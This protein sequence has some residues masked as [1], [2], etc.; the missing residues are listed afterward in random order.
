MLTDE[1]TTREVNEQTY[2]HRGS[3]RGVHD[4]RRESA[5]ER[6]AVCGRR[7]RLPVRIVLRLYVNLATCDHVT[8]KSMYAKSAAA[9]LPIHSQRRSST[10]RTLELNSIVV[11]GQN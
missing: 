6:Q 10:Y 5:T 9:H 2:E 7:E 1:H 11:L 8:M 4:S 3:I